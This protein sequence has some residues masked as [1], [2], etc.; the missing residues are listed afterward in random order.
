MALRIVGFILWANVLV[1]LPAQSSQQ[2]QELLFIPSHFYVGDEVLLRFNLTVSPDEELTIEAYPRSD[3]LVVDN[4]TLT[5]KSTTVLVSVQFRSFMVGSQT[6]DLQIGS[7]QVKNIPIQ[8]SSLLDEGFT[9]TL[10]PYKP[11]LLTNTP[12]LLI[13]LV[14]LI[15][16]VPPSLY[17]GYHYARY[18][19]KEAERQRHS[20]YRLFIKEILKLQKTGQ[21]INDQIY[22]TQLLHVFRHYLATMTGISAFTSSTSSELKHLVSE[23][24]SEDHTDQIINCFLRSD[25]IRFG[26]RLAEP[27]ER[28]RDTAILNHIAKLFLK[29][30]GR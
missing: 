3:T 21:V 27:Q 19:S 8:V 29:Q 5:Q 7:I 4:I 2:P 20:P 14:L 1:L 25:S 28:E 13:S 10:A 6:L 18:L 24:F 12:L 15:F 16:L 23:C 30:G 26:G 9:G 11:Q 17:F 22:Y